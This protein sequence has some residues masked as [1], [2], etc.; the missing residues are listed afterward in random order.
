MTDGSNSEARGP[1]IKAACAKIVEFEEKIAALSGEL[2]AFR[3]KA[4]KAD[5]G[6]KIG[7]FNIALR[8]YKLEGDDRDQLLATVR[9]TFEALGVGDQLNWVEAAERMTAG[10]EVTV[11][12]E[13]EEG[14]A[15][16]GGEDP[17]PFDRD[18]AAA[19]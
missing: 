18:K 8:L 11:E 12:K 14:T 6:M 1:Q 3:Q 4:V 15:P 2:K 19:E 10:A 7:D 17:I 13:P 9:E 16:E 5:L